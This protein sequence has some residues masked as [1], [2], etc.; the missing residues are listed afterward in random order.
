V[1]MVVFFSHAICVGA[2]VQTLK[3]HSDMDLFV[4]SL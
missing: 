4:D 1:V 2:L 3:T